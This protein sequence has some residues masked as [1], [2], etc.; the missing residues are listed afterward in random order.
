MP[1]FA[2]PTAPVLYG[3]ADFFNVQDIGDKTFYGF[4]Y[5]PET[6]KLQ[7]EVINDGSVVSLPDSRT[8]KSD[9]YKQWV[10]TRNNLNFSW[11][12]SNKSHLLVEVR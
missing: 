2:S 7:V 9:D 8:I 1:G 11:N 5:N 4:R 10:W 12:S 3:N 6:A